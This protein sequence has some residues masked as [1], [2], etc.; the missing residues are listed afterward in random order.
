M[1]V[2][3]KYWEQCEIFAYAKKIPYSWN[4]KGV[5]YYFQKLMYLFEFGFVWF[6]GISTIVGYLMPDPILTYI[7][8]VLFINTFCRY[9][10][11]N[12]KQFYF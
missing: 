12:V 1:A 9:T 4:N 5:K 3:V 11:L 8:N 7:L 6:Y 2:R 10:Q